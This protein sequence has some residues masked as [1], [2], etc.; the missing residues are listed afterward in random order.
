MTNGHDGMLF[1][2]GTWRAGAGA[3]FASHAPHD[4]SPVWQGAAAN[5]AD[6]DAAYAAARAAF[7]GWAAAEVSQRE[8]VLRAYA[9]AL[10]ADAE[11]MAASIAREVGKPLW[12]ARAEVTAMI[13]KVELSIQAWHARSGHSEQGTAF[14]RHALRHKPHGVLAVFGPYNFPGH[15]PNGHIVPALMAGNTVVFK[16]SEHAPAVAQRMLQA[17][18]TAGLPDGVLN[19][20]QGERETGEAVAAHAELDGLY[21]TGS[22]HTGALLHRQFA[23]DTR[24]IL[25]LEMG[26][27][28]PLVVQPVEDMD[29]AAWTI[30]ESAFITSGQRCTCA[31][32]LFVPQGRWGERLLDRLCTFIERLRIGAWNAEPAPFMGPV[33]SSRAADQMLAAQ[34][35]LLRL[36]GTTILPLRRL[37]ASPA[38]LTPGVIDMGDAA[39][40]PD[41][42]FF[43]PL[44]QVYRHA[45]LDDALRGANR[46][47]FG[48][49]AGLISDFDADYARFLLH[50]R[51][52]IVNFNRPTTGASSALPFGGIGASGNHRAS[53]WYAAD[54]CAYPVAS[55]EAPRV[56]M[57]EV[58]PPGVMSA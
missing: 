25:A 31:R 5:V 41:E 50:S 42:E 9:D 56:R 4:L 35:H 11:A 44:L 43:G 57:P 16:P 36:G 26:G 14:G 2:A 3:A 38:F 45:S 54:Y 40:A 39:D 37:D 29:A 22:A 24:R 18:I 30:V 27:N 21:F 7:P 6:V 32:R 53:A 19:L 15:L 33:V 55:A 12:E 10:R 17:W 48:L 28:N 51:A 23:G 13:G 47:R 20:V 58:L 34:Q 49:A 52:G 8:A 1:I 46:T